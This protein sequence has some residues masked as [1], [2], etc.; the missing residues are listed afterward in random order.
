MLK[1]RKLCEAIAPL[2]LCSAD[3]D[4]EGIS[5]AELRAWL[6]PNQEN[7]IN[8]RD[9]GIGKNGKIK[10]NNIYLMFFLLTLSSCWLKC[11]RLL[12]HVVLGLLIVHLLGSFQLVILIL[13]KICLKLSRAVAGCGWWLGE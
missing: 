8:N 4:D 11:S 5:R 3:E 13:M 2:K 6:C 10:M 9:A 1:Q 7:Y 12:S